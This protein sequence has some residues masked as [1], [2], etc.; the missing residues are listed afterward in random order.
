MELVDIK[1]KL[2]LLPIPEEGYRIFN[3]ADKSY[4]GKNKKGNVI[5]VIESDNE[6]KKAFI[7]NTKEL[8]YFFNNKFLFNIDGNYVA[9]TVHMLVYNVNNNVNIDIF[10][11]LTK[12]FALNTYDDSQ[13]YLTGLFVSLKKLFSSANKVGEFELQGLYAELY[14]ILYFNQY[15]CDIVEYWQS[16]SKMK[17]DFSI[18]DKKRIEVKSTT[19]A[20]RIHKFRHE[21]LLSDI[22]DIKIVSIMLQKN[23]QG[24]SLNELLEK[25]YAVYQD[26]VDVITHIS[27]VVNNL[28]YDE[29]SE[30]K[31][32]LSYTENNIA[33]F[34][35]SD[36]PHFNEENPEGVSHT[37]YDSDLTRANRISINDTINW[38][39]N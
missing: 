16:K 29:L 8:T 31:Y 11:R 28:S 27:Q 26:R 21:Q 20:N 13:E 33:I 12:A 5:F 1:D 6:K 32:D 37:E 15:G 22:Y 30:I 3:I 39:K 23:D 7:Q 4:V 24:Q 34:N 19:K 17:F 25:V 2:N 14:T 38:I 10:L 9:K 18:N 36:I 35:A